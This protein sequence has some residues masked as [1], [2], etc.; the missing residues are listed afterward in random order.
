MVDA[1]PIITSVYLFSCR[2]SVR[3]DCST[4]CPHLIINDDTFLLFHLLHLLSLLLFVARLPGDRSNPTWPT[5]RMYWIQIAKVPC[6]LGAR[7]C[8]L[9]GVLTW[10]GEWKQL[11]TSQV[12]LNVFKSDMLESLK[13]LASQEFV[14][15]A[16]SYQIEETHEIWHEPCETN[17]SYLDFESSHL[18][19]VCPVQACGQCW[20]CWR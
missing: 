18:M 1:G 13:C 20:W 6:L 5:L 9:F 17:L 4:K 11:R 19:T 16:T 12:I 2:A 3:I 7:S 14:A 15:Q 10:F 8:K